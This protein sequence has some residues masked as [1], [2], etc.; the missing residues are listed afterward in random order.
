MTPSNPAPDRRPGQ[1][2]LPARLK[3]VRR[4]WGL[5]LLALSILTLGL[6]GYLLQ[7]LHDG[8]LTVWQ[9]TWLTLPLVAAIAI[10]VYRWR[11][12]QPTTLMGVF[13][14][15]LGTLVASW[16]TGLSSGQRVADSLFHYDASCALRNSCETPSGNPISLTLRIIG[17]YYEVFGSTGFLSAIAVGAFLG[18]ALAV[19]SGKDRGRPNQNGIPVD[20]A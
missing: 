17:S 5:L 18:Y 14:I 3:Q 11:T 15:I 4:A 7:Q 13:G 12:R 6:R 19:L 8:F 10:L 1:A 20:T 16:L 9:I 2:P